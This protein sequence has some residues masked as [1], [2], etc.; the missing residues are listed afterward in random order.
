HAHPPPN[1]RAPDGGGRGRHAHARAVDR[2]RPGGGGDRLARRVRPHRHGQDRVGLDSERIE[3]RRARRARPPCPRRRRLDDGRGAEVAAVVAHYTL[4][5]YRADDVT[6][7]F[8][9]STDPEHP[10]P[11]LHPP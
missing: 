5:V 10:H 11:Y 1:N 6:P 7:W 9:V 4:T 2:R 3:S 8:E